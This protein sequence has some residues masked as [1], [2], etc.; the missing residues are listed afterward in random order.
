MN[1]ILVSLNYKWFEYSLI[2]VI[3]ETIATSIQN[4]ADAVEKKA[5]TTAKKVNKSAKKLFKGMK[6]NSENESAYTRAPL[7]D[8]YITVG[9]VVF[10]SVYMGSP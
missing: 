9:T 10:T 4:V 7:S 2:D 1:P 3:D 6:K 5:K 8:V